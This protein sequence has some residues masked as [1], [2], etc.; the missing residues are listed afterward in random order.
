VSAKRTERGRCGRV[1][2]FAFSSN[3]VPPLRLAPSGRATSPPLRRG[4]EPLIAAYFRSRAVPLAS[5]AG[6]PR[7][8]AIRRD[9]HLGLRPSAVW[10]R[11]VVA[12][13]AEA[14]GLCSLALRQAQGEGEGWIRSGSDARD[15]AII[16]L[17]CGAVS[18]ASPAFLPY[19][20]GT[21]R[22]CTARPRS[23]PGPQGSSPSRVTVRG[24]IIRKAVSHFSGSCSDATDP[25]PPP[26]PSSGS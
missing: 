2:H 7:G 21:Q 18:R 22:Q 17:L 6:P 26:S 23:G 5:L 14:S 9:A 3:G 4:E 8:R 25:A 13:P 15:H 19:R 11:F 24:M 10:P 20:Q 16:L 12:T 1:R